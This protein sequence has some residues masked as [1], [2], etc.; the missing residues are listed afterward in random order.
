MRTPEIAEKRFR[1]YIA[2]KE[3]ALD[4]AIKKANQ[5]DLLIL[6][7]IGETGRTEVERD[8]LRNAVK[9]A[10][11]ESLDRA[12]RAMERGLEE[13]NDVQRKIEELFK[14]NEALR[15]CVGHYHAGV[16]SKMIEVFR[17]ELEERQKNKP[18]S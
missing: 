7:V 4:N 5:N 14:Q 10:S 1:E 17:E 2:A 11:P 8:A 6:A 16:A 15:D 13:I 12:K 9:S 3:Q 18:G